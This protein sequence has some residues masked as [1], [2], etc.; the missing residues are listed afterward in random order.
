M[1]QTINKPAFSIKEL[2]FQIVL[3]VLVFIFYSFDSNKPQIE[4]YQVVFFLNYAFA[5]FIINYFLLPKFFY[6]KKYVLFFIGVLIIVTLVIVIEEGVIEKIYFPDSRGKSFPGVFYSLLDVL[7]VIV[8]LSGFKFA[9][10][11]IG[12]QREV[13]LLKDAVKESELQFLKTQINP[14]FLFNNLNNLYSYAIE[15][16]P[17]TPEIILELSGV[18]RYMLYE[19]KERFV[20][21]VKEVAQIENFINLNEMQIEERGEVTFTSSNIRSGYQIAPLILLVFIENA[22]K[23]STASQSEN[24]KINVN[25]D[26]RPDGTLKFICLNSYQ[27]QSNTDSLANGIGLENVQKRLALIYPDAHQLDIQKDGS[28]YTVNLSIDLNKSK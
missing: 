15:Q 26:L 17:K 25:V 18:L 20:P 1:T 6:Q 23:H 5:T 13:D 7:P 12:K 14:H 22:F 21:L 27:P 9:W 11:A 24:I 10:D 19:C 3:H 28:Q 2:I 8:I 16:S 4:V